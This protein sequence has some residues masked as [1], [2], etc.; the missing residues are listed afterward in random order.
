M[1]FFIAS[2]KGYSA[3]LPHPSFRLINGQTSLSAFTAFATV[4]RP[5]TLI[6]TTACLNRAVHSSW[7]LYLLIPAKCSANPIRRRAS[8]NSNLVS[9]GVSGRFVF[10]R[11]SASSSSR[12]SLC[13]HFDCPHPGLVMHIPSGL[14]RSPPDSR[15]QMNNTCLG[16]FFLGGT[17]SA[18]LL[19]NIL[20]TAVAVCG[21]CPRAPPARSLGPFRLPLFR[22]VPLGHL[23]SLF[24]NET[25]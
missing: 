10:F 16:I 7:C 17:L 15:M 22:L 8:I 13:A 24:C 4:T 3:C 12:F 1:H 20:R 11:L 19:G 25:G 9:T 18:L 5:D 14:A 6:G 2:Y 23:L 21:F